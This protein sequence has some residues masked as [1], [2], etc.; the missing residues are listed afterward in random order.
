MAAIS[1]GNIISKGP[2]G[3]CHP[4]LTETSLYYRTQEVIMRSIIVQSYHKLI[5]KAFKNIQNLAASSGK[6]I[7]ALDCYLEMIKFLTL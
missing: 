2:Q 6:N 1:P 4:S 5:K 3:T 7:K